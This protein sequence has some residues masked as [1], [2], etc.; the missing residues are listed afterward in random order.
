[1]STSYF[2]ILCVTGFFAI[3]SSTIAKSPVLPLYSLSIGISAAGIGVVSAVSSFT[4]IIASVPSGMMAERI[5][6]KRMLIVATLIFATAPFLYLFVGNVWQLVMVRFYHGLATAIFMP[7]AL[8]MVSDVFDRER[9]EK[10]GWFST[11]TLLGRFIAPMAGGGIIG[12][13]AFNPGMSYKAVY[14]LCAFVGILSLITLLSIPGQARD[15]HKTAAWRD[16]IGRL[17]QLLTVKGVIVTSVVE[18]AVLFSYGAFETFLPLYAISVGLT[19]YEIGMILSIQVISIALT[20]PF[21]GKFSDRHGR[22]PQIFA[23]VI[24]GAVCVYGFSLSD[25]FIP[26][27]VLSVFFGLSISVVTSATSALIADLSKRESLASAMG[28]LASVMDIGH[29]TGPLVSGVIATYLSYNSVFVFAAIVL[30]CCAIV[31]KLAMR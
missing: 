19:P 22:V 1:M 7:V 31:F 27:L 5:G 6:K 13:M 20:K 3:F 28:I 18:G 9:G 4:G 30:F 26:L 16:I 14:L 11:S 24:L 8:S 25:K 2:L 15:A 12:L 10:I 21:M 29:T 17:R 23:G